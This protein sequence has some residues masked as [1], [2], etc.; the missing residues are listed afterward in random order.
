MTGETEITKRIL[1]KPTE[2]ATDHL[3]GRI[4]EK[5]K[6]GTIERDQPQVMTKKTDL[7]VV[8]ERH[9]M[10]KH[11][12]QKVTQRGLVTNECPNQIYSNKNN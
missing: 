3:T 8:K 2:V 9:Q 5:E 7:Q 10:L 1:G 11:H 4:D 12:P 6:K